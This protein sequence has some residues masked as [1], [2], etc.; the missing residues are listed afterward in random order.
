M[1]KHFQEK[2]RKNQKYFIRP[3]KNAQPIKSWALNSSYL[4]LSSRGRDLPALPLPA[5]LENKNSSTGF[6]YLLV[7]IEFIEFVVHHGIK[8]PAIREIYAPLL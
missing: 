3:I 8:I 7:L 2:N 1:G 5:F 4:E 6:L